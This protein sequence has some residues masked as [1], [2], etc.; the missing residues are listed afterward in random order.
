MEDKGFGSDNFA[1]VSP[2]IMKALQKASENH[3]ISYGDDIYTQRAVEDFEEIFGP[4]IKVYFVYNGTAANILG[5]S[6]FARS[7]NSVVCA[8]T[9]HINVDECGATEKQIGCKLITLP[10]PDGKLNVPLIKR[11][12][13]GFGD[14]HHSQPKIISISQCTEL[15]TVYTPEEI[16]KI[17]EF[18]HERGMY[19]HMD[20]ARFAN[21]VAYLDCD[22]KELT[23]EAG[24]DVM[25]FGGTKNGM[26]FGEA[27]ILF[28]KEFYK[29]VK[30]IRKQQMQL[31]SK[32]RFI[33]AQFSALLKN[34]LWLK[35]AEHANRMARKLAQELTEFPD[36]TITQA[37]EANSVFAKIPMEN[38]EIL[39][40]KCFFYVWDENEDL[41][42]WM[43]AFDT[44][45]DDIDDFIDILRKYAV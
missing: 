31:H 43:C 17:T 27:V 9:A 35:N 36:I 7:Y 45:E 5:L 13:H 40:S 37:V 28:N 32:M 34:D 41:V 4:D 21:A 12:I 1:G 39:Q 44:E 3:Q 38:I 8:E 24:I 15:G 16:R 19:V 30:F 25:S 20:G 29:E 42:R 23:V 26:M 2:E 6:V 22:P 10:T 11:H 18:A 33:G 14:Q